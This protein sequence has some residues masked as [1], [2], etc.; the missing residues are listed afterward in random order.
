MEHAG[1]SLWGHRLSHLES[2]ACVYSDT[3]NHIVIFVLYFDRIIPILAA[4]TNS[5][6]VAR[7]APPL[8]TT[9]MAKIFDSTKKVCT[10]PSASEMQDR[11]ASWR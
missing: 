4:A 6:V 3:A 2:L 8:N 11:S 1:G 9:G 7:A 10:T 5:L